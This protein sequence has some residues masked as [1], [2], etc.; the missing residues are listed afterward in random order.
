MIVYLLAGVVSLAFAYMSQ[1]TKNCSSSF[2]TANFSYYNTIHIKKNFIIKLHRKIVFTPDKF[3]AFLSFLPLF[4]VSAIRYM[5]GSDY[6][7]TYKTIYSYIYRNGYHFQ[8]T[9]E[10]LY[11]LLNR[12]AIIYSGSDY[13]GVFALSSLLICGFIFLGIKKQSVNFSYSVLLFMISGVYFWSFNGVRQSIAMGIFIFALQYI[14]K[15]EPLK[16]FFYIL[17]AAGF[18]KMALIYIPIYFIKKIRLSFKSVIIIIIITGSFSTLVRN[19]I[20]VIASKIPI[21]NVYVVRYLESSRFAS[22]TESSSS[23]TFINLAFL[24][25]FIVIARNYDKSRIKSNLWINFQFL[26]LLFALLA[27]VLPL[28]NRISRLFA[29]VQL[30][31]IPSMT[32]LIK[33]KKLKII[34]N[35]GIIACFCLYSFVTFYILGYHDVFPYKTIFNR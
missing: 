24:I 14:S 35:T 20:Y 3:L 23:H 11:A 19:I 25:L 16:Y 34:I 2:V 18:H 32:K 28:A 5:V 26:A 8:L 22:Y 12:I 10:P 13:V 33:D 17:I 29:I 21:F 7:G 1:K 9:G 31:S 27:S 4:T 15:E 6:A 30:I